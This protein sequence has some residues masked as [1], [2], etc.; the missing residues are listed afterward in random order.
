MRRA[1]FLGGQAFSDS[2]SPS[3]ISA[4]H[5]GNFFSRSGISISG[6]QSRESFTSPVLGGRIPDWLPLPAPDQNE[7]DSNSDCSASNPE[8]ERRILA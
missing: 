3:E 2:E 4:N 5:G 1:Q 8:P 7:Q 6:C